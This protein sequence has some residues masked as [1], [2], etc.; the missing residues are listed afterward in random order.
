MVMEPLNCKSQGSAGLTRFMS[1]IFL[2]T[3]SSIVASSG[4]LALMEKLIRA[5]SSEWHFHY[6][7]RDGTSNSHQLMATNILNVPLFLVVEAYLSIKIMI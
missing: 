6:F 5:F 2:T 4:L 3:A 1:I 7:G